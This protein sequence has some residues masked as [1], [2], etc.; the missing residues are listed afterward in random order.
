M[1]A[2]LSWCNGCQQQYMQSGE[3]AVGGWY[4][5]GPW[6]GWDVVGRG[7]TGF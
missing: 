5:T 1:Q 6:P 4:R 2:E 7:E 3:A